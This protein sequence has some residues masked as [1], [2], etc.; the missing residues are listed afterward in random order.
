MV[1]HNLAKVGVASSNLVSRSILYILFIL[2]PLFAKDSITIQ[3]KYCIKNDLLTLKDIYPLSKKDFTIISLP[4]NISRYKIPSVDIIYKIKSYISLPII[5]NSGG[6]VLLDSQCFVDYGKDLIEKELKEAF[7]KRYKDIKIFK[8]DIKPISSFPKNFKDF[9]FYKIISNN[10][11]RKKEG[12]FAVLYKNSRS[13]MIRI[14]FR[15][16]IRAK[17]SLFKAKHNIHNGKILSQNDYKKIEVDFDKIPSG[18]VKSLKNGVYI[19]K[20]YIRK[21]AI[22]TGYMIKKATLVRKKDTLRSIIRSGGVEIE[23]FTKALQ[24]GNKGDIIKTIGRDGRVYRAKIVD[25]GLVE[26]Q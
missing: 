23:F 5:D 17:I 10:N 13:Q 20:N 8:L 18:F 6:I 3:E 22:I 21:D 12:N 19:T 1:E 26:I 9:S 11:L 14:Y 24:N 25:K 15:Y 4:K 7:K 2:L 16:N